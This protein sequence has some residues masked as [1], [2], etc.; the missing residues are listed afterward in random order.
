MNCYVCD[1]ED[2]ATPA[3]ANCKQCGVAMC[4]THFDHD[5]NQQRPRGMVR[6]ACQHH[7]SH[8]S[9]AAGR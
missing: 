4:R 7:A 9:V 3:V 8:D 6:G 5:I 1:A 2:K